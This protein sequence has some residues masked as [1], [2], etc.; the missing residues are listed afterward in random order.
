MVDEVEVLKAELVRLRAELEE[1][2]LQ[3][4]ESKIAIVS[5]NVEN[6]TREIKEL[7]RSCEADSSATQDRLVALE[8][9][10]EAE[11]TTNNFFNGWTETGLKAL[12]GAAVGAV[13]VGKIK[14]L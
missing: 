5:T 9:K 1:K 10:V 12:I 8:A 3:A 13:F 11:K 7:S 2:K 6:L 14:G 4:L